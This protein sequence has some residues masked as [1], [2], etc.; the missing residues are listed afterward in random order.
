MYALFNAMLASYMVI[1]YAN[2]YEVVIPNQSVVQQMLLTLNQHQSKILEEDGV[3]I[4]DRG[5]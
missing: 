1:I 2:K 5:G 3:Q 4:N